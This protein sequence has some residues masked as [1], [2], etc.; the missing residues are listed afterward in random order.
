MYILFI[1]AKSES[2]QNNFRIS[3]RIKMY[4]QN[5]VKKNNETDIT[6]NLQFELYDL[7]ELDFFY[8]TVYNVVMFCIL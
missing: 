4:G 1:N 7:Y 6:K 2:F 3:L 5:A 8:T